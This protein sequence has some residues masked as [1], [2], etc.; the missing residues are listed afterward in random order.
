MEAPATAPTDAAMAEKFEAGETNVTPKRVEGLP[1]NFQSVEALAESYKQLQRKLSETT[2]PKADDEPKEDAPKTDDDPK[3]DKADDEQDDDE[4]TIKT[5]ES[6]LTKAGLTL[7]D[8]QAEYDAGG[9][10]GEET[11]TKLAAAGFDKEMVD[12]FIAGQEARNSVRKSGEEAAVEAGKALKAA[13]HEAVGGQ[14]NYDDMIVWARENLD[15]DQTT[16]F[17]DAVNSE[18]SP[19]TM[20]AIAALSAQYK[21]EGAEPKL[22]N[23]DTSRPSTDSFAS[24]AE[25][26]K[27]MKDPRYKADP[28]Y[29][30]SVE[31]KLARSAV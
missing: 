20:Q 15:A 31:A 23:G 30:K 16:A 3:E 9:A 11:Y 1:E 6:V 21:A 18:D 29:Q 8:V 7:V 10:L 27:A 24:W 13:A 17:N 28:A 25:V 2:T 12:A 4:A 14:K 26:T 5:A 19:R 22:L